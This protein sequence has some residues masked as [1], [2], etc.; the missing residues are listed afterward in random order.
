MIP[1]LGDTVVSKVKPIDF[2]QMTSLPQK[3]EFSVLKIHQKDA[4][5]RMLY[6]NIPNFPHRVDELA[7]IMTQF[8][9]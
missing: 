7:L 9:F 5:G 3:S 6:S 1:G 4:F 8:V 2:P